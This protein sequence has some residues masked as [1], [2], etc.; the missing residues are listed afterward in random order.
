MPN[1]T[2]FD[3]H[4]D[5]ILTNMSVAYMQ[6]AYA[7]VASRAFPQ[8]QVQKQTDKYFV[9][10]QADFFRD[11][12]QRR[13][14]GTQSAGTGYS[15]STA[16]YSAE[17]YALHKDIGDQ[18]RANA[19]D[20]LDMD[21]DA[22]RFLT[23]QML[24]R[25]EVEW[26]SAA[27]NTGIWG[28]DSTPGVLWDAANSTPIANIET[29]KN[30]VLTATGYVPNT[31]IMSYKVFSALMDNADI[32]DRI[33]YTSVESVSEDLLA[34]LFNVDRVLIM[35]GTY[36]TAANGATASYSQIGDKDVLLCYTPDNP[37]L[38]QPS[39]GYTMVW[40]G[41][42]SGMGTSS[43]ISRFR[44]E[45][46]KADRIEIEAAWDTKIVSSALGYFLSNVTS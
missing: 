21:M 25:Q 2:S 1:P 35:A 14:D 30:A 11:Q 43:A 23:Q 24:I 7:F 40:N 16:S 37:G 38:M 44:L 15:L 5:A 8:V 31:V 36:N 34:R 10:D 9:Y 28:T 46:E 18:T 3:V 12:V 13:A 27:F 26:A 20:P 22:T 4:V 6:E 32:V 42:S 33:K 17:V 19:D 41:V 29:G 39:A 45:A